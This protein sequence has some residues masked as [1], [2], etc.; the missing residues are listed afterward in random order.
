MNQYLKCT[1]YVGDFYG[2]QP[3][4]G[5]EFIVRDRTGRELGRHPTIDEARD[6][7]TRRQADDVREREERVKLWAGDREFSIAH[8]DLTEAQLRWQR[9]RSWLRDRAHIPNLLPA[10][11]IPLLTQVHVLDQEIMHMRGAHD[12][13]RLTSLLL[14]SEQLILEMSRL[15]APGSRPDDAAPILSNPA[16]QNGGRNGDQ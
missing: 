15:S 4:A 1:E 12:V 16:A 2:I 7:A 3:T 8:P 5:G 6:N 11:E 13:D 10:G 9:W 14:E